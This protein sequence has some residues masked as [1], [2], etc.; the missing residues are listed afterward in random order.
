[1]V[2][3][4]G[5]HPPPSCFLAHVIL[6]YWSS[7]SPYN[8]NPFLMQY[9]L[10]N[11]LISYEANSSPSLR[12]TTTIIAPTPLVAANFIILGKIIRRLGPQYSRL[13]PKWCKAV[14][15]PSQYR[16][17]V[18]STDTIVFISFDLI[19]LVVQSIG[20][21][22][23]PQAA[24]NHRDASTVSRLPSSFPQCSSFTQGGNIMLG[25]VVFQLVA[26][27]AYVAL[28]PEFLWRYFTDRPLRVALSPLVR[29]DAPS[30][31]LAAGSHALNQQ[32]RPLPLNALHFYPVRV[33]DD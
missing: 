20:G 30:E 21:A 5:V 11:L 8:V 15:F 13:S 9:V 16:L 17:T 33:S 7:Q 27:A 31:K 4:V 3:Q 1:L 29:D 24:A 18:D 19:A 32:T 22:R 23:A 14:Q 25:G 26:I 28:A 6:R 12:I 10:L 2:G